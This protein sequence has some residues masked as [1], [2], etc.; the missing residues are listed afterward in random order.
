[1]ARVEGPVSPHLQIY[2]PQLTSVLSIAH[3]ATGIVLSLGALL[4]AYWLLCIA[5]GSGAYA[6]FSGYIAAWYGQ[7]ILYAFVFSL[8]YHLCNGIRHLFWDMGSG[9]D[10]ETTYR[11]GYTVIIASVLLT[12][13]TWYAGA[14]A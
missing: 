10:L 9:L 8:Y 11:S 4:V 3:R 6:R 14:A 2:K 12:A 1:M 7:L 13:A 5:A